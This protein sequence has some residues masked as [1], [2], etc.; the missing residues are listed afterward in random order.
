MKRVA[1]SLL[2]AVMLGAHDLEDN[3]A[4]LIL[5]DGTHLSITLYLNYS[6]ALWEALLPQR[7]FGAFL[8]SY[9]SMK[10]D[11]L[12][13][14]L[15]RAQKHFEASLQI[16]TKSA[17]LRLGNWIWPD[18]K[19]V[20]GL[21]QKQVMQAVVEGHIHQPPVEVHADAVS[22]TEIGSVTVRLPKEFKKV[23]VVSYRPNQVWADPGQPS[24]E[25][26]F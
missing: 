22:P 8:L 2:L 12:Q 13:R 10:T 3:R 19:T 9:S 4:T 7:E 5:R 24:A 18:A 15:N 20:Q 23:L 26:R 6:E 17:G 14:E 1:L 25:I 11:D 16:Q 21:L